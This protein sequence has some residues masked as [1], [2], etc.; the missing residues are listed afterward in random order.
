MVLKSLRKVARARYAG[1]KSAPHCVQTT[2]QHQ[3]LVRDCL[4]AD[5][6]MYACRQAREQ[7]LA[8]CMHPAVQEHVYMLT[9]VRTWHHLAHTVRLIH[10]KQMEAASACC[11]LQC[12]SQPWLGQ[13][14]WCGVQ[15]LGCGLAAADIL[16]CRCIST[17]LLALLLARQ[18]AVCVGRASHLDNPRLDGLVCLAVP[19]D[20][21]NVPVQAVIDLVLRQATACSP[22][23][24]NGGKDTV[25]LAFRC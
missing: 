5:C 8:C 4:W 19:Y 14:L 17:A 11:L 6:N 21:I 3:H 25:H 20:S 24:V 12:V 9:H 15:Q 2:Y 7:G 22:V 16:R 13:A 10:S 1:R 18:R 23:P